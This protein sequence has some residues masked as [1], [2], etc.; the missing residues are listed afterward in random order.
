[1]AK[2]NA[3][4]PD[5]L[6]LEFY[7][8]FSDQLVPE[9][10]TYFSQLSDEHSDVG[11]LAEAIIAIHPKPGRDTQKVENYWPISL[12]NAD[13]KIYAKVLANRLGKVLDVLIHPDQCGFMPGR[14]TTDNGRLLAHVLIP[15]QQTADPVVGLALDAEK[16]FDRLEWPF[17]FHTLRWLGIKDQF[18]K[19][20]AALYAKPSARVVANATVS[21]AFN[22]FRGTR[23]GC[24][25]SPLL[26]NLALEPLA[27]K[28]RQHK[29]ISGM[30]INGCQS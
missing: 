8:A 7:A 22:L 21:G 13:Y 25:L 2:G 26:F 15:A 20:I 17:L 23:Q 18:V 24:P 9:M 6:P 11:A 3:S 28:I 16:A 29:D 5:G 27:L 19:R 4:G 14:S 12:L 1:M 30:D 10:Q